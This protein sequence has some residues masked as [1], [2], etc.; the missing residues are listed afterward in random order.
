MVDIHDNSD[1][2]IAATSAGDDSAGLFSQDR[3]GVTALPLP[4]QPSMSSFSSTIWVRQKLPHI[5][6]QTHTAANRAPLLSRGWVLQERLLAPRVLHFCGTELV[7]ECRQWTICECGALESGDGWK[8]SFAFQKQTLASIQGIPQDKA[9]NVSEEGSQEDTEEYLEELILPSQYGWYENGECNHS[10]DEDVAAPKSTRRRHGNKEPLDCNGRWHGVV[11]Q[12]SRLIP[13]RQS[14]CLPALSGLARRCGHVPADYLAGLWA[15]TLDFDILWRVDKLEEGAIR[16]AT[17]RA[18]SWSWACVT[19]PVDYW[20][21]VELIKHL[22]LP[23]LLETIHGFGRVSAM[24]TTETVEFVMPGKRSPGDLSWSS[25][26]VLKGRNPFGEVTSG[27][28]C[29]KGTLIAA[30]LEYT[31]HRQGRAKHWHWTGSSST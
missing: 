23:A 16:P 9:A 22:D 7:W 30:T 28:L 29:V 13:N 3:S 15:S 26:V 4:T 21:A 2:T 12:F 20:G 14:D 27:R 5:M 18:P 17:Y 8:Q 19:T 11:E 6:D 10:E 24:F 1:I 31:Y 25:G